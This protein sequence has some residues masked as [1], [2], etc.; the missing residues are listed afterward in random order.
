[1]PRNYRKVDLTSDAMRASPDEL[2]ENV[3]NRPDL[4]EDVDRCGHTPLI[5]A[6]AA[7]KRENLKILLDAGANIEAKDKDGWTA[8]M[9]AATEP[10]KGHTEC[11]KVLI[12]KG[13]NL[14]ERNNY[15]KTALMYAAGGDYRVNTE[16][17]KVLLEAGADF[18]LKCKQQK[19]ALMWARERGIKRDPKVVQVLEEFIQSK[20]GDIV[21]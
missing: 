16:S 12:A 13:A 4:L 6:A 2:L 19:T 11:V 5:C 21:E 3:K 18:T 10:E 20:G 7:G 1:M 9:N 17:T 14:D 8:L 15:G